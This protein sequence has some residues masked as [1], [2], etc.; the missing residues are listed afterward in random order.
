MALLVAHPAGA[1]V[2]R[3]QVN[4]KH[5]DLPVPRELLACSPA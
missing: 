1:R 5:E 3:Y 2:V 4:E